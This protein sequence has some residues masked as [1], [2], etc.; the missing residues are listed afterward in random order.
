MYAAAALPEDKEA[1][2]ALK[3]YRR[4]V[5]PQMVEREVLFLRRATDA[6]WAVAVVTC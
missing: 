2:L 6:R 3:V 5:D 1:K 4:H